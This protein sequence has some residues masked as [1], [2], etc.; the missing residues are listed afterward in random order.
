MSMS[1]AE[2]AEHLANLSHSNGLRKQQPMID[3][4]PPSIAP[5]K[6]DDS[7][8]RAAAIL[9]L[10]SDQKAMTRRLDE[11]KAATAEH[12]EAADAVA[13]ARRDFDEHQKK[14]RADF[15]Q[16]MHSRTVAAADRDTA[17]A[18][19]MAAWKSEMAAEKKLIAEEKAAAAKDR[20][21]AGDLLERAR[22][23]VAAFESA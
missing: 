9:K 21:M 15:D 1:N 17:F 18:E 2:R 11:L 20:A 13:A 16:M 4:N 3:L 7:L 23:K 10:V 19:T 12:R 8:E 14:E 22:R 6:P 5:S